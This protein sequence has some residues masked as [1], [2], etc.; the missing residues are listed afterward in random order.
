VIHGATH[1]AAEKYIKV[2]TFPQ[3]KVLGGATTT[4]PDGGKN[5]PALPLSGYDFGIFSILDL[6]RG[7]KKA[8]KS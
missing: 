7:D 3:I 4:T 1:A 2:H 8:L 5:P 6:T